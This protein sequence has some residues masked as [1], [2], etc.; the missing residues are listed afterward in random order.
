[1]E[2]TS[3]SSDQPRRWTNRASS[4]AGPRLATRLRD[5]LDVELSAAV[6]TRQIADDPIVLDMNDSRRTVDPTMAVRAL[7]V[8]P[9]N[10]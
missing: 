10:R 7:E 1:M 8:A 9:V 6:R 4:G 2:R 3:R 5:H